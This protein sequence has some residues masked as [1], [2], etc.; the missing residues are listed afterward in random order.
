MNKVSRKRVRICRIEISIF[1]AKKRMK[2]TRAVRRLMMLSHVLSPEIDVTQYV[3]GLRKR[4]A[5][6]KGIRT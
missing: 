2:D 1:A 5:I 4:G 3:E 6:R